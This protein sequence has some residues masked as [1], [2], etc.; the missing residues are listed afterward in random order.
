[1][2]Q[3]LFN[4]TSDKDGKV[5]VGNDFHVLEDQSLGIFK[6]EY[7]NHFID[8]VI[9]TKSGTLSKVYY[10]TEGCEAF[11]DIEVKKNTE[12]TAICRFEKTRILAYVAGI[13]GQ[14]MN[15]G[16]F[17]EFLRTTRN[18]LSA[19]SARKFIDFTDNVQISKVKTIKR[20]KDNQGNFAYSFTSEKGAGDFIFPKQVSFTVPLLVGLQ[21][22]RELNFDFYFEWQEIQETPNLLFTLKNIRL[23]EIIEEAILEIIEEKLSAPFV[24]AKNGSFDI[25]AKTDEWKYKRNPLEISQ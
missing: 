25:V 9:S 15:L 1:M 21:A 16:K 6:T 23:N 17:E 18:Y 2:E 24:Y 5:L 13:E 7:L 11:D 20:Q 12:P 8:Y 22:M 3:P 19:D 14:K 4:I 10:T